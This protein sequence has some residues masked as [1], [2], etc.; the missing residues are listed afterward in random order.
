MKSMLI[1]KGE[2][3]LEAGTGAIVDLRA[4][5]LGGPDT[6]PGGRFEIRSEIKVA[7]SDRGAKLACSNALQP[8]IQVFDEETGRTVLV[9]TPAV[10][11]GFNPQPDP[12]E[13]DAG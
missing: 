12:P 9:L 8:T 1:A 3:R 6:R 11:K 10:I 4:A 7:G 13:G 5:E 2:A